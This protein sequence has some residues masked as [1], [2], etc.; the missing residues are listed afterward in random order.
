MSKLTILSAVALTGQMVNANWGFGWCDPFGPQVQKDI[1]LERYQ[2]N[3]YNL[4]KDKNFL[5]ADTVCGTSSLTFLKDQWWNPWPV[6]VRN[7]QY[8]PDTGEVF[9]GTILWGT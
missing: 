7:G 5:S 2:G 1:D 9:Q 6:E 4:Q 3:W 8:Y